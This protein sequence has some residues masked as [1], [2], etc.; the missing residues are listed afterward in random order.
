[1]DNSTEIS[2][3]FKN[4]VTGQKKLEQY[5]KTLSQV[6]TFLSNIDVN[7]GAQ[8]EKQVTNVSNAMKVQNKETKTLTN[9]LNNAFGVGKVLIF[10]KALLRTTNSMKKFAMSSA[11]YLENLNLIDVAFKNNTQEADKFVNKLSEMY[12]LDESWGYRQIGIFKQLANAMGLSDETGTQLAKTLTQ[13][14]IDTSSLYNFSVDKASQILQSGLAG[15]TKPVRRLGGD[16]T[17]NTLQLTLDEHGIDKAI[18]D[19]SYVEKRLV[20]VTAL[21]DQTKQAHGDWGRTIE[22]VANQMRIFQQ[23]TERVGRAIGN[24]FLVGLKQ[25][26]P[27]LNAIMMVLAEIISLFATFI[28]F[29]EADFDFFGDDDGSNLLDNINGIGAGL[30]KS[31]ESAKKLKQGLR[32]FDKLNN[33]TTPST[34]GASA[35]G[36]GGSSINP[37]ILKMF[38]KASKDYLDTLDSVQMKAT[39]IRDSIMEWLGFTKYTDLLTGKTKFKYEGIGKTLSNFAKWFRNLSPIMKVVVGYLV[40]MTGAKI[41]NGISTLVTLLGKTGLGKAM[42]SLLSPFGDLVKWMTLGVQVNGNLIKG[43]KDGYSAWQQNLSA[44]DRAK[45]GFVELVGGLTIAKKGL[46]DINGSLKDDIKG[47]AEF[48]GGMALAMKGAYDLGNS[49][50]GS[51]GSLGSYAG[52]IA[53]LTASIIG[54]YNAYR[55]GAKSIE[56]AHKSTTEAFKKYDEALEKSRE[57]ADLSASSTL[58]LLGRHQELTEELGNYIDANGKVKKEDEARVNFIL[59]TLNDAYETEYKLENGSITNKGKLV[60]SYQDLKGNIEEYIKEKKIELTLE[61]YQETYVQTMRDRKTLQDEINRKQKTYNTMLEEWEKDEDAAA[62]KYEVSKSKLKESLD[63]QKEGLEGLQN[64]IK[65]YDDEISNYEKL[66]AGNINKDEKMIHEAMVYY[67]MEEEKKSEEVTETQKKKAKEVYDDII[68]KLGILSK[69][70]VDVPVEANTS[71]FASSITNALK[72][73]KGVIDLNLNA[74]KKANGGIF[75][76]KKWLDIPQYANSGLPPVGQLFV[77]NERGPEL[78]GHLGGQT[79]VANQRQVLGMMKNNSNSQPINAT[80]IV[81]VGDEVVATKVLNDLQDMARSNG[82]P[83]KIG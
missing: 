70:K 23:Q 39:K 13:L 10:G 80:F 83:I 47:F 60:K 17:Q 73:I 29:N 25:I 74:S 9:N 15:Q 27:Y 65:K 50:K 79:F 4:S 12:G 31:A 1:M 54:F 49:L 38:N 7:K 77:A 3:K 53:M 48:Y 16:I 21:L 66:I 43:I 81:Q 37:E 44:V 75:N 35:S 8:V 56:N 45:I 76:G 72:N 62:K 51:L 55:D 36:G 18:G 59:T 22:S 20:I 6:N 40:L 28:G 5:A 63:R 2:L 46:D 24:V 82:K 58:A 34:S 69:K 11:E 61:A 52:P 42:L 41:I 32:G 14:A 30:D 68:S 57:Q 19:L 78:V 33:I 26:L 71:G 64:E 67:G